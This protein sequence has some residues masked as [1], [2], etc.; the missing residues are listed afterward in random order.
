[1]CYMSKKIGIVVLNY[2]NYEDT[3]E[4]VESLLNLNYDNYKIV[5]VD[6]GSD[7]KSYEILKKRYQEN[8]N[9][10]ILNTDE[11]FGYA[12]GNN[13]GID[14][15]RNELN[16]KHVM[17]LNNDTIVKDENLLNVLIANKK[18]GLVLGP[19]IIN[20]N[21]ENQN[22]SKMF[23]INFVIRKFAYF[24][25]KTFY[26]YDFIKKLKPQRNYSKKRKYNYSEDSNIVLHGSCLFFT[27]KY[28][29]YYNGFFDRTF[30]YFEE[31]IL[32]LLLKKVD[33]NFGYVR[34]TYIIHKEDKSSELAFNNE[35]KAIEKYSYESIKW[36]LIIWLL[37]LKIIK[38]M[39]DL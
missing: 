8:N 21:G 31:D 4:C 20:L 2:L 7:N 12:K 26:V 3:I 17:I 18:K 33:N 25:T 32:Y 22:P 11:N 1:M 36:L 35:K 37:P 15:C 6:N 30:L 28:F 23:S 16:A 14:F 19:R 39:F 27:N 13:F 10:Y 29:N 9:I 38:T 24:I 34:N 5:I